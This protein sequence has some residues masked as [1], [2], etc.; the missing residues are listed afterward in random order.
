MSG[1]VLDC[2]FMASRFP[3]LNTL[4][5][6][7]FVVGALDLLDAFVFFGLRS[8][9]APERI[10]Q[11]IAAGV[12]GRD[13]FNMS[14]HSAGL[15]LI[16][17]FFIAFS[18]VCVAYVLSRFIPFLIERPILGGAIYGIGAYL[19]MNYVVVP[20]SNATPGARVWPI[21]LNGVLIHIFGVG[22]PSALFAR[23]ARRAAD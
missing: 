11:S 13:A 21:V 9:V 3:A 6:G 1:E 18:I 2:A 22:I 12:L 7:G 23:R 19:V 20:L 8:G 14:F 15:G 16:L 5:L 4:M 17:H 10:L